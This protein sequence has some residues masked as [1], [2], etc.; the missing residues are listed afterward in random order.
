MRKHNYV[1]GTNWNGKIIVRPDVFT[2][3]EA[4]QA[5][6]DTSIM[7]VHIFKLVEVKP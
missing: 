6:K 3:K 4:R 5:K 2:L 1:V 7:V